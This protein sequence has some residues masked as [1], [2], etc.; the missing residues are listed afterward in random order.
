MTVLDGL[1]RAGHTIVIVTPEA[2]IAA[3]TRRIV[4][5]LDGRIASD[6]RHAPT[7]LASRPS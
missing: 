5:L 2:D 4:R 7:P 3:H 6:E 1:D